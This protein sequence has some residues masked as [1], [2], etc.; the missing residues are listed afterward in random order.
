MVGERE[1]NFN[2]KCSKREIRTN[3]T[4]M[5]Y[6]QAHAAQRILLIEDNREMAE[7]IVSV[8]E[9]AQ[10][11]VFC[12]NNGKQ[13]VFIAQ[14]QQP[15]LI[16][17]D[18]MMPELDGYGVLHIL[19]Q[20]PETANIPFVFLTA[21]ADKAELREGM[22]LGADDYLTKPFD[23]TDLLKVIE[24]RLKK[25]DALKNYYSANDFSYNTLFS[26]SKEQ[27]I[28]EKLLTS[29]ARRVFRKKEF[30]YVEAQTPTEVFYLQ[31]GEIKTY[32]VNYDGKELITGIHHTGDFFGY[33]SVLEE[34]SYHEN[35][36]VIEESE[37]VMVPRQEFLQV[38]Y[39]SKDLARKFIRIIS[40]QLAEAENRLVDLAYQS[41]RQRVAGALLKLQ[42][43]MTTFHR[44]A[45]INICRKD[46]SSIVGTATESL[47]RTL[48]D[49]KDE[50]L[51]EITDA[52]IQV[53][54][55]QKLERL[56]R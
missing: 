14:Q 29:K 50:Q 48:A 10:Y 27:K 9:L 35:A 3:L 23:T 43:L 25:N 11:D 15:D 36:E 5:S 18:I 24:T 52:G 6:A 1:A 22:N 13:G 16:L 55:Q 7:N 49:F 44:G 51:I 26:E 53:I 8:L 56:L 31:K 19:H 20:D 4:I 54:N 12:A 21:R 45:R 38:V 42:A 40:K 37:I 34:H 33:T 39:S 47:N 32:K 46:L 41:V 17:C 2:P 30:V 28:L